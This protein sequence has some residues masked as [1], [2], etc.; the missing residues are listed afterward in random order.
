MSNPQTPQNVSANIAP[1]N[2]QVP[3]SILVVGSANMDLAVQAK[4]LPARGET[5]LGGDLATFGGGKGANQAVA[6]ARLGASVAM[7]G[8]LGADDFGVQLR[9]GLQAEG[10]DTAHLHTVAGVASGTAVITVA[11]DGANTIVVS[12]GAN[13]RLA[14]DHVEAARDAIDAAGLLICQLEVPLDTVLR[15]VALAARAGTPV[16]LNPAPAQPL[17]DALYRQVDFLILNETEAQLLTGLPVDGPAAAR[18]AAACLLAKGVKTV[19]VTLGAQGAWYARGDEASH[20]PAPRVE[21]IDTTAA[22]DTFVGGF[23]AEHVR[24]A[25]LRD[26]IEFG[27]QAAA[28]SVTRQGAQASIPTQAEV[29]ARTAPALAAR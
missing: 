15:A 2:R 17:P 8:C 13:A 5:L 4:R 14:P 6:A 28:L 18:E 16:L 9:G 24:G 12:P 23:A 11:E 3:A 10:I 21:A 7:L 19:I 1:T 22:G 20:L 27:Q 25:S 26:A 29:R